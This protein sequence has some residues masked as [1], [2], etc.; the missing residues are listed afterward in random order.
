MEKK[1]GVKNYEDILERLD[2][3]EEKFDFVLNLGAHHKEAEVLDPTP[4]IDIEERI[5][6][7]I[8]P[9]AYL[10]MALH[11][12]KYANADIPKEDWVEVIGLMT[13]KI[14]NAGTPL[15]LITVNDYWAI[16]TGDAVSVNILNAEPVMDV[17]KNKPK[18]DFIVGWA[19][20]HPSYTP[21]L[22][23]DDINTQSRYQALWEDS[24]AV[25]IDPTM[26]TKF[27]PGHSIFRL[28]ETRDVYYEVK[29]K[30]GGMSASAAYEALN[31]LLKEKGIKAEQFN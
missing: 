7:E 8:K 15:E 1:L 27:N 23:Q 29:T 26:I 31:L 13:G 4:S 28:T 20:S 2:E 12:I 30:I 21:F 19:H 25:V 5:E 9:S 16:G 6:V 3:L 24:I 17:Y 10:K 14:E 11:A 22:S 18:N